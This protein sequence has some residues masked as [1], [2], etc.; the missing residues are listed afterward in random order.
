MAEGRA[1]VEQYFNALNA[2][3]L[4][5]VRGLMTDDLEFAAPGGAAG[6]PEMA[7]GWMGAFLGAFPGID[8]QILTV[9]EAGDAVASEITV[10]GTHTKPMVTP[11]G[12]VPPT[13]KDI[14]LDAANIMRV[15][16][17]KIASLH[18]YFDQMGFM[19]QLGLLPG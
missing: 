1:L 9:S 8:H 2:N 11:Q 4:G 16:D 12:E 13:G 6:G 17:G 19:A 7:V 14:Q 5:T 3:D 18:I 10:K 15:R